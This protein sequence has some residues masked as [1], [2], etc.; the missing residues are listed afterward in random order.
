MITAPRAILSAFAAAMPAQQNDEGQQG[1]SVVLPIAAGPYIG[2]SNEP[3]EGMVLTDFHERIAS[4]I[5]QD[6]ALGKHV[7]TRPGIP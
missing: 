3:S 2:T 7:C 1:E 5:V 6:M 4:S